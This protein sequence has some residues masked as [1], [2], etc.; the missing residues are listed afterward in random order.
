[1]SGPVRSMVA[2][3]IDRADPDTVQGL[4]FHY[5]DD[6]EWSGGKQPTAAPAAFVSA[7]VAAA[8]WRVPSARSYS[9][10]GVVGAAGDCLVKTRIFVSAA[11]SQSIRFFNDT[12]KDKYRDTAKAK[13]KYK[14]G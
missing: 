3:T 13:D 5:I 7:P 9:I 2:A 6:S 14:E 4:F 10:H 8:C 12:D 1:M 11:A